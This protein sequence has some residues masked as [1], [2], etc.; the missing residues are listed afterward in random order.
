MTKTVNLTPH[1]LNIYKGEECIEAIPSSGI[2]RARE[3]KELI[4][5]VNGVPLVKKQFTEIENLPA[6]REGVLYFVSVIVAQACPGREDLIL[7]SSLVRDDQGRILGCAEF[8]R[9]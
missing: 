8:A 4:G 5:D 9:L 2:A 1:A 6:P 3:A 7:S